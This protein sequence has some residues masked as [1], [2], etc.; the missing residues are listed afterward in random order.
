MPV[1][2]AG[3]PW[4]GC[5]PNGRTL[6]YMA[7]RLQPRTQCMQ[8]GLAGSAVAPRGAREAATSTGTRLR[9]STLH[10]PGG[11]T[12]ARCNAEQCASRTM[13]CLAYA[14]ASQVSAPTAESAGSRWLLRALARK[15]ILPRSCNGD[16]GRP[17]HYINGAASKGTCARHGEQAGE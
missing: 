1:C 10:L 15:A 5:A 2:P 14:I 6:K 13:L 16:N 3:P 17:G 9:E 4:W 8:F 12:R 7:T 11:Q